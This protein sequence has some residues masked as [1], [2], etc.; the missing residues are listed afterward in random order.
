LEKHDVR[1]LIRLFLDPLR[2]ETGALYRASVHGVQRDDGLWVGWLEFVSDDGDD[3]LVTER[4]T[5]QPDRQALV[6]WAFGLEPVYVE[7][8]FERARRRAQAA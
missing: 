1:E 5:T 8:A 6:Y 4:E 7:G 3:V 2:T